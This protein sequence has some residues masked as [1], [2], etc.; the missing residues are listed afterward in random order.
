MQCLTNAPGN[1]TVSFINLRTVSVRKGLH[2]FFYKFH[3]MNTI[4]GCSW[5]CKSNVLSKRPNSIKLRI[6]DRHKTLSSRLALAYR[7]QA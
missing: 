4:N 3:E 2:I 5:P 7:S 6:Q 1:F